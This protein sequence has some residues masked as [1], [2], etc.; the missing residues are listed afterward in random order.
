MRAEDAAAAANESTKAATVA[1]VRA[2]AAACVR[3][4][5]ELAELTEAELVAFGEATDGPV[6][7]AEAEARAGATET[8]LPTRASAKWKDVATDSVRAARPLAAQQNSRTVWFH[9]RA[10]RARWEKV[11]GK[12]FAVEVQENYRR[13]ESM[14]VGSWGRFQQTRKGKVKKRRQTARANGKKKK[15][16]KPFT[17]ADAHERGSGHAGGADGGFGHAQFR[18]LG[19]GQVGMAVNK[20]SVG[21]EMAAWGHVFPTVEMDGDGRYTGKNNALSA[22][23][24]ELIA[25]TGG[26]TFVRK[27]GFNYAPRN[28]AWLD[29]DLAAAATLAAATA[30]AARVESVLAAPRQH[31]ACAGG[32]ASSGMRQRRQTLTRRRPPRCAGRSAAS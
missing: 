31:H 28:T 23:V 30:A 11:K 9:L 7:V 32:C 15:K 8:A 26:R 24:S 17:A 19:E 27:P 1:A 22:L 16:K 10:A 4:A 29:H 3:C 2:A 13:F 12:K 5:A 14:G 18:G 20:A 21:N 25:L 6:A